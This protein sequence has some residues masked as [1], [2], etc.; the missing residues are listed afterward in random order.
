MGISKDKK[1]VSFS[2]NNTERCQSRCITCNG[3][4]TPASVQEQE[5]TIEEWKKILLNLH[6]WMGN[7]QFI[8]SGGEPFLRDDVFEMAEYAANL[9]DTVNIVTNGLAL[10]DKLDKVLNSAFTNITFSL[11]A[12]QNP[13][14]HNVSRG[15][16]DAFQRTIDS[17]QNLNYMNKYRGGH[18]WKNIF[19][20]TVV[21]PTNL[22]EIKPIAEFCKIEGIGVSFQLMDNG[23]AFST[24]VSSNSQ[25]YG[26]DIKKAALDA[27]DEMIELK[28]QGYPIC[29]GFSQLKAFK[30]LI[31]TP[32]EIQNIQCMVGEN[33]FAIDPYG[34]CRI[35]F[36]MK[37]IGN[38]KDSLPQD[39]WY[40]KE[41]D[42]VREYILN[43][44][45]NCR[46]LNCNFK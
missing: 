2:F 10:P 19:L 36:C 16:K 23:D 6:N 33:N 41:A 44:T 9:G 40:S 13:D 26:K 35:C 32:D 34:N 43:C 18:K 24:N 38:L 21:M 27:I 7:Y 8:I 14:I 45:R 20:S 3:W 39:L 22:S 42:E 46:L 30:I 11:N 31:D 15:R 17:I 25:I 37:P 29:N 1:P 5:L 28:N 12:I 4:K